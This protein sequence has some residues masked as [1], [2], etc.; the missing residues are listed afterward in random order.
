MAPARTL[1]ASVE[2]GSTHLALNCPNQPILKLVCASKSLG[3]LVK[4]HIAEFL[5]HS[6]WGRAQEFAF[7]ISSQKMPA[8][9]YLLATVSRSSFILVDHENSLILISKSEENN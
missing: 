2:W 7:L 5:V 4:A 6:I 3:R 1:P 8:P 9:T